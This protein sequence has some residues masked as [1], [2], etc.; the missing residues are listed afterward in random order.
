M[1]TITTTRRVCTQR[2]R[3]I[4][5]SSFP[6][7]T[8]GQGKGGA[9]RHITAL[10]QLVP[11]LRGVPLDS[12]RRPGGAFILSDAA[13]YVKGESFLSASGASWLR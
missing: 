4:E 9:D 7:H 8:V 10:S 5:H 2:L 1:M 6:P 3:P 13:L 11:P 12:L